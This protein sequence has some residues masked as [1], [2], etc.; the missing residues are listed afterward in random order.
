MVAC[1]DRVIFCYR[2]A[3]SVSKIG[4]FVLKKKKKNAAACLAEAKGQEWEKCA[5]MVHG[6]FLHCLQLQSHSKTVQSPSF[7]LRSG[8]ESS[9]YLITGMAVTQKGAGEKY[10]FSKEINLLLI[11][12]VKRKIKSPLVSSRYQRLPLLIGILCWRSSRQSYGLRNK[13]V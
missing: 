2:L 4:M 5:R 7:L 11:W 13:E 12:G 9:Y 8:G 10:P 3:S 6:K 1:D